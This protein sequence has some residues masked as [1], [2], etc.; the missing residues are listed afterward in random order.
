MC[1]TPLGE[2]KNNEEFK[3]FL[4]DATGKHNTNEG[5]P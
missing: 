4:K 3:Y 2:L 5:Y 1:R